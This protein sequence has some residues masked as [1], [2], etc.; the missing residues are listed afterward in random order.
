MRWVFDGAL[1]LWNS[2][3]FVGRTADLD[4]LAGLAGR[5]RPGGKVVM[6][7]YHP[8]WLRRNEKSGEHDARG[9]AIRRWV[10]RGHC[11][12][13]IRYADGTVDEIQFD[14]YRPEEI[15]H[16]CHRAG[17]EP[18]F[19]MASWSPTSRPSADSPRYQLVCVRP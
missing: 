1:V 6:D 8:E 5:V 11:F 19:E 7:L 9:A 17:L 4:T 16:L 10:R 18:G 12:N 2:I 15:R 13:E 14:V 3:G